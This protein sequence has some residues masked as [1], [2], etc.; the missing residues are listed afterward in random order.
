MATTII[1]DFDQDGAP[2]VTV[3]GAKGKSCLE[4]TAALEKALG[5]VTK[6]VPTAEMA[7]GPTVHSRE[8]AKQ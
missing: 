7:Q 8:V 1:L 2:I 6:R 5:G 3:H 4:A